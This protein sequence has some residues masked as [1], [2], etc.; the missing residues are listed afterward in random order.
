MRKM[1]AGLVLMF[2]MLSASVA[3]AETIDV[4]DS[5]G[6][7]VAAYS[8]HWKEL[9]A[10]GVKVRIVGACQ[11]A[12][13]VLLGYIPRDHICVM[14]AARFGFHTA[15]R[16][17]MTAVLWHAYASDIQ[18]WINARGGLTPDFKWMG[19]PDTY[20]YFHKC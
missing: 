2:A 7:S 13:T 16:P 8:Q 17:D 4:S 18:G 14:P 15:H 19:A 20:R 1:I 11:S 12:C 10:R 3:A 6:G 5:H 9:A